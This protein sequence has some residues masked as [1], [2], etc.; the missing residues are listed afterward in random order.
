MRRSPY[1]FPVVVWL[2]LLGSLW[3]GAACG[4]DNPKLLVTGIEPAKGSDGSYVRIHGNR[5][6]ADGPRSVRVL[7]GDQQAQVDRFESDSELIVTAPGGNKVGDVVNVTIVFEPGGK[8]TL[9]KAF[10][11]VEKTEGPSVN[12]LNTNAGRPR[13]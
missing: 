13:K 2:G 3:L 8:L 9:P 4:N 1:R 11:Y 5:F 6:M 10:R 7:F 12:D